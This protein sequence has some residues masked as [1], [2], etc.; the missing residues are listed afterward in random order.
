[1]TRL[2]GFHAV[3]TGA[4]RGI[5]RA[6]ALALAAEGA[7]VAALDLDAD[8]TA[9]TAAAVDAA[10]G[11]AFPVQADVSDRAQVEAAFAA[12]PF[13]EITAL[14]N[15]AGIRE[16]T[17]FADLAAEDWDRII[18]VNLSGAFYCTK[19]AYPRLRRPGASIVSVS[20]VAGLIG[21]PGRVAY[22]AA[23]HGL[24]G[25]TRGMADDLGA[26]GI[27]VNAICPG[28]I[29]TPLTEAY[30][31]NEKLVDDLRRATPLRRW[32]TPEEIAALIVFLVSDAASFCTGGVYAA[33][34]GYT[35]SKGFG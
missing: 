8:Q 4:G 15:N 24:I 12:L 25:L 9:E 35:A 14:V 23:K 29:E 26:E 19:A 2:E 32:G 34:G 7:T 20:S 13:P 1:M 30:F 3:V 5:G 21:I 33:D 16:I 28:V 11:T 31:G 10:G 18:A 27:R 17:R 6:T 22:S